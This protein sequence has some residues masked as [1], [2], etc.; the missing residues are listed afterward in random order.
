MRSRI[1]N[2][3][4]ELLSYPSIA[5]PY[6]YVAIHIKAPPRQ[7]AKPLG[8]ASRTEGSSGCF[9][10]GGLYGSLQ[11]AVQLLSRGQCFLFLG[12]KLRVA[13]E[14]S[15]AAVPPPNPVPA[16]WD[17]PGNGSDPYD[18]LF[19]KHPYQTLPFLMPAERLSQASPLHD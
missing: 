6:A 14:A 17:P 18:P 16:K 13:T 5:S 8:Q 10:N 19:P 11:M 4:I 1:L 12:K 9:G 15:R 2:S 7:N 3:T